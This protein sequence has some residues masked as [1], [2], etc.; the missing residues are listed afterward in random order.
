MGFERYDKGKVPTMQGQ[1]MEAPDF[2]PRSASPEYQQRG[3]SDRY[4]GAKSSQKAG[5]DTFK[6]KQK[7]KTFATAGG[8]KQ[9]SAMYPQKKQADMGTHAKG[10]LNSLQKPR[11]DMP[12][13]K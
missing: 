10:K 5:M 3:S 12:K 2:V 6:S 11:S 1:S 8:M 4:S 13:A 7:G 9:V